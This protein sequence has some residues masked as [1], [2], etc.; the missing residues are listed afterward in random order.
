MWKTYSPSNLAIYCQSNIRSKFERSYLTSLLIQFGYW[1]DY[2]DRGVSCTINC[3]NTFGRFF[4][5][6]H[7][8]LLKVCQFDI[9]IKYQKLIR[10]FSQLRHLMICKKKKMTTIVRQ[11]RRFGF[12]RKNN[13][14]IFCCW[15]LFFFKRKT[16]SERSSNEISGRWFR[17]MIIFVFRSCCF[18]LLSLFFYRFKSLKE[19]KGKKMMRYGWRWWWWC[20]RR[21]SCL[22]L[23]LFLCFVPFFFGWS[24]HVRAGH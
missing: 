13:G 11:R 9:I 1:D 8:K 5:L 16:H 22:S 17:A 6:A 10:Y 15:N 14:T 18:F 23:S 21:R 12:T 3:N 24:D 7:F 2:F 19:K 4:L 20:R